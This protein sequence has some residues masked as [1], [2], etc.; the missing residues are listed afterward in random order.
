MK[1]EKLKKGRKD[2]K[3]IK[4]IDE[5]IKTNYDRVEVFNEE[6]YETDDQMVAAL[7]FA[8]KNYYKDQVNI[9]KTNNRIFMFRID[10]GAQQ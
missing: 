8:V 2:S 1:F 4:F 3:V 7:R 10:K 5:F 9:S 6:D